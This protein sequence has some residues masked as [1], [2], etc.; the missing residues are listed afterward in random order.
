MFKAYSTIF[1][2]Q[3]PWFSYRSSGILP[4]AKLMSSLETVMPLTHHRTQL[5]C[6]NK[7]QAPLPLIGNSTK[8]TSDLSPTNKLLSLT[9]SWLSQGATRPLRLHSVDF[10]VFENVLRRLSYLGFKP[11]FDWDTVSRTVTLKPLTKLHEVTGGWFVGE[12]M[13][14]INKQLRQAAICGRPSLISLGSA[15]LIAGAPTREGAMGMMS[16]QSIYLMQ[17]DVDGERVYVQD[18]P[19]LIVETLASET[20]RHIIDKA[21]KY[22]FEMIG[23]H[24]VVICDLTNVPPR[25]AGNAAPSAAPAKPF[26]AEIAVWSRKKTGIVDLDYPLDPCYH[27]EELGDHGIGQVA[28]NNLDSTGDLGSKAS[29]TGVCHLIPGQKFDS[30]AR[31]Y[32]RP[33]PSNPTQEQR[34]HRRSPDWIVRCTGL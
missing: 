6:H 23:V 31:E 26:K 30:C 3:V 21:F 16:D 10:R 15:G 28:T 22:L 11:R 32:S 4:M 5:P 12:A 34:I 2:R 1:A 14:D 7:P 24:A 29:P 25:I 17:E 9:L 33:N 20:R 8:D 27:H 18:A 13:P 19:R